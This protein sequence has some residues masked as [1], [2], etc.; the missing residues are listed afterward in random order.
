M[1]RKIRPSVIVLAVYMPQMNGFE[2]LATLRSESAMAGVR[3]LMLTAC[4][5][6]NEIVRAF[7][8][9]ADDYLC[10]PFNPSELPVRVQHLLRVAR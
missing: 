8:L 5:Q 9:G 3:V 6:E 4:E 10:K 2:V 7:A 1:A